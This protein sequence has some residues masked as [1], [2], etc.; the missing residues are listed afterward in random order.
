MENDPYIKLSKVRSDYGVDESRNGTDF[1]M[2][3]LDGLNG[4]QLQALRDA[5]LDEIEDI[6][7]QIEYEKKHCERGSRWMYG[8]KNSRNAREQ[9]VERIN[10]LLSENP[11][12]EEIA[13]R[14]QRAAEKVLEPE[15]YASLLAKAKGESDVFSALDIG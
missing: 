10:E 1:Y 3:E 6:S 8:A 2:S 14:F 9:F 4:E 7:Y 11:S 13:L 5:L 12:D 15:V